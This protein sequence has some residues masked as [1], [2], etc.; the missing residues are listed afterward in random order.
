MDFLLPIVVGALVVD[1]LTSFVLITTKRGG[2]CVR[3]WYRSFG[4]GAYVMDVLSIIICTSIAIRL[5]PKA[6]L[7]QQ[8]AL[9][10]SIQL[11]HDM[12]FGLA[13]RSFSRGPVLTLFK[14]YGE[15]VKFKILFVDAF[16]VASTL[17]LAHAMRRMDR[18]DAILIGVIAAYV[19][20]LVT[21]SY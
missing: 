18:R 20:L 7:L 11:S 8:I 17:L 4:I 12:L 10:V 2:K 13:L 3:E 15:E 1:T 16:M 19:G 6:P 9:A 14:R 21:Y 5:L